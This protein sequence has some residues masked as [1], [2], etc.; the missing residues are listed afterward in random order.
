MDQ[1]DRSANMG[2]GISLLGLLPRFEA[3]QSVH[4]VILFGSRARGDAA[5]RSDIDM[6]VDAPDI[7]ILEWDTLHQRIIEQSQTL[8]P[9]DIVWLQQAPK[10]LKRQIERDGV[11]IFERQE[12]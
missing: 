9:L 2:T 12:P 4:R 11:V 5:E 10:F 7:G 1:L 8:L 3:L 6:A